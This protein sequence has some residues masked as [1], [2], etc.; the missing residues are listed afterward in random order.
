MTAHPAA[1]RSS[2][3]ASSCA[4]GRPGPMPATRSHGSSSPSPRGRPVAARRRLGTARTTRARS[5]S[6]PAPCGRCSRPGRE[7]CSELSRDGR[8]RAARGPP[9]AAVARGDRQRRAAADPGEARR[10]TADPLAR[11]RDRRAPAA[12][13]AAAAARDG[14]EI[15]H[16]ASGRGSWQ[17]ATHRQ[18]YR[19][20]ASG[21]LV[22]EN[23][24]AARAGAPRP[25]AHRR[26]A[27]ASAR[28]RA[29]RLVRA[30]AVGE[31]PRPACL[32]GRRPLP[33][34]R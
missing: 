7:S 11:P 1:S 25:A 19:L 34:A 14:V 23:E 16:A 2:P 27:R 21:E 10:R 17:D 9:P 3:S 31:L 26:R 13:R 32:D 6:R 30:G 8:G 29:A 28:A 12:A 22:V 15:V 5:C 24:R 33:R 4:G 20:L 18:R